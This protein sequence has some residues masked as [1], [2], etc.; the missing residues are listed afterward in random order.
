MFEELIEKAKQGRRDA[1][2]ALLVP[3]LPSLSAFARLRLSGR[4]ARRESAADIVQSVCGDVIAGIGGVRAKDEEGFR[5][6]LFSILY[7]KLRN[8]E[9]FHG[10]AK[11]DVGK[12]LIGSLAEASRDESILDAYACTA[13]PSRDVATAEAVA[14]IEAAFQSL[15]EHYRDALL[16]VAI[17]GLSYAD[18]ARVLGRSEDSV[19][20]LVFRARAR[21]ATLLDVPDP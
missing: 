6:W 3:H 9:R 5:S 16:H 12:E 13:T 20:Q 15:P 7:T 18:T 8:K 21:L 17:G 1:L 4:L 19:R 11:R 2:E 10:A 14:R